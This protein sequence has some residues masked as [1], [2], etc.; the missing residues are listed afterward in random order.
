MDNLLPLLMARK[1]GETGKRYFVTAVVFWDTIYLSVSKREG[2][3][4]EREEYYLQRPK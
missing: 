1:H 3:G 4:K 2:K